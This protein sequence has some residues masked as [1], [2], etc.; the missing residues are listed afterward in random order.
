MIYKIIS[1]VIGLER[2]MPAHYNP[3]AAQ[4]GESVGILFD[5]DVKVEDIKRGD[6]IIAQK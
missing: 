3:H 6:I 2:F 4:P 5:K 1:K